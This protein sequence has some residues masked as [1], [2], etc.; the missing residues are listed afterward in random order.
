MHQSTHL[1]GAQGLGVDAPRA[2]IGAS[3]GLSKAASHSIYVTA[4][5][6]VGGHIPPNR[7]FMAPLSGISD[8]PFRRL[9]RRFGAGIVVSEMVASGQFV[10]GC[11]ESRMRAMRD[12]D[13]LH[14]VQ[15]AGRD[16]AWMR[17][18]AE[19]L[20]GE[21]ADIIDINMGC[22][23]KKVVGG[24]SG[25]ALMREPEL[26]VALV[27]A[28]VAGAGAVP[29]TLKMRLGWDRSAMN[30]PELA[31]RAEAAGVQ[32]ITVHGRTRCDFYEGRA[33]WAA[34]AAVGARIGIPLVANGDV[35]GSHQ[36]ASVLDASGADAVM[37]GRGAQGRPWLPGL[38]AGVTDR[39]SLARIALAD[40]VDEHYAMMLEHYGAD[41]A[42]RHAR[43]HLGWYLDRFAAGV[44]TFQGDDR[45]QV[46]T[47]RDPAAVRRRLRDLFADASLADVEP[48]V[49]GGNVRHDSS[50]GRS[51]V[52][53]MD[54]HRIDEAA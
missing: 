28:T 18:A 39:D 8:V 46:M 19:R 50:G 17:K 1:A 16:P 24:Q 29:V 52:E 40:L 30:A 51:A 31:A 11:G 47:G 26:A 6:V 22:P 32:M 34:I 14:V 15:L 10:E 49:V 27:E 9:A 21:G 5:L 45:L 2:T 36:I 44:A 20:A 53:R 13:G 41:M 35:V 38:I 33:D 3:R 23:A 12:G 25:S 4:P 7:V 42:V 54:D 37:I 48:D 43:K